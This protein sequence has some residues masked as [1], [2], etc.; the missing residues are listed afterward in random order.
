M[1]WDVVAKDYV[2]PG[3]HRAAKAQR[4]QQIA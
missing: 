4:L 2:V 3:I 1:S